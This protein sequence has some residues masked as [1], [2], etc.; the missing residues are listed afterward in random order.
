MRYIYFKAASIFL[1]VSL[2]TT[3]VRDVQAQARLILNGATINITQGAVLVVG[4]PSADAITRNSGYIIS[5]GENNAIKWY[6]GTFTGNYTIP[7]GY[8]GDYIPVTFTP[9]SASG[10]GYFIFSTY[11]TTN[12]NN[13]ANLPTG[14]TDFNGSSG[15][16]QSAFAIDRFWQV[17]AVDYTAKPLLSSLTFTYRDDEH[18]AT[19]NTIDE[20]S[21]RPERWNSTINTWT[22]FSS[23]PTLN[24]TNNTATITTLNAADLYAWWTLSTSQLNRYWVASSLS[25]WNNRSNWS[26]SAGGPGG[27]TVPLTT[28]AV[29]FDGA[30]DGICILDTDINIASLL[31]ASDYSG[32]VNQGSHR[33]I[34][35]DD[36][37]FS[38]GTFQGGSALIQVNGDIAIDGAT[39]NSSTDTLDVKSNFTFNTGTFNHNNGTVKFSGSTVGV[40]QLI[41]GTAVTDFN[42]IYVANSASNAGVRV[43]SDQN[44]QGILTLAPSAVLDADGSSNTAIFTLMSLNDNPVA[45]AGIA[46]LPAGAQ[47]SGNVTVQRYMALEGANNTRIYRYIASPVQQGTV[48]DIQQEI[49]VTGSFVG[50]SNCKAC[51]TNQSMFEYDEAVTTDTNGSGFVD[52]NDG[53]IDFPSIVNT[54]VLRPGIGYT[55]FVR[56]NYLTS[57]VWDIRG[58]ANQGNISFPVTFTSSGNIANDGWNLVGNPYPSVIDWNAAGWTKTNIDGTIYIPDNGGIELQYASWNGTLGVNGGSRYIAT[59]QGFWVKATASPVFSATEAIKAAGQTAVFFRTA[60]LENLLRIRLSNGSFED[61]TV[62]HFREDA[63]TE[64]DS[65]ADAWKLKN[66]GFNLSTVTEKNE[67][68]AINSMPT[69]SCGTQIN[70]DVADTKPGSYKLKF[71]NLG[72]FQTDASLRLIDH[73]LNQTIPVSGEYI[74]S[75]SITD[76][77]ESKGDQRFTVVIDKPAP[78]VVITES[79]GSLTVDYTQGIQWYKDGAMI[80]GATAPS[81]T[82]EEPGI[83]TVN[84]KVD[85]CTLTGMKEFFIT[86]IEKGSKAI[87]VYPVPVTDKLSIKVD[88]SRKLT[89]VSVLNVF[90]NEIATTDLQLESDNT[91]TGTIPMKDFPAGSYIVQLKGREGIISM[92]VVKK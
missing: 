33:V 24:T 54:E 11:H 60:S 31:V 77:P 50:S 44:L 23:T 78:D 8:N 59:A 52:V 67:R 76:A 84:V 27:A 36:A 39:L 12:W 88:A 35:G 82:P 38:G 32:S 17:N 43:E 30:N 41:S 16:D 37:T 42:N 79:A 62:I 53:Y 14:V 69:L 51:L 4:N 45:D 20:N 19:G 26:V 29:I 10:S 57:P 73:Y 87:K 64:F 2:I 86:G 28:D 85:G 25:N 89:S 74:Y 91:Y 7:W 71:S 92:K 90:G 61:E 46:T 1:A 70:L 49:P 21:L 81:L 66:G 47:V 56:G 13:A 83:Y 3:C 80:E 5:E 68:L 58:V 6:I 65:H 48:A 55:I 22:D 72:S 15:S 75:F 18:S 34:V 9:S 40:P 63:T